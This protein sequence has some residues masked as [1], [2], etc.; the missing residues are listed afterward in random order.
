MALIEPNERNSHA[1]DANLY[2]RLTAVNSV[3]AI[4][5][6]KRKRTVQWRLNTGSHSVRNFSNTQHSVDFKA[7]ATQFQIIWLN[8]DIAHSSQ[9]MEI[10]SQTKV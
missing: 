8:N 5:Y 3:H 2:Y 10:Q 6:H 4:K 1:P 7:S 9:H